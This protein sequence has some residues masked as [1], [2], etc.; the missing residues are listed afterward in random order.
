V[1]VGHVDEVARFASPNVILL[2]EV[3]KEEAQRSPIAAENR[4]RLEADYK[5]LKAATDQ[6]GKPFTII[7]VPAANII[8]E[9]MT[10]EDLTYQWLSFMTFDDGSVFP[11]PEPVEVIAATG[12]MNYV[13]TNGIV[14]VPKYY[15]FGMPL[16]ILK[17]DLQ[18]FQL[19]KSVFP[20]RMVVAIDPLAINLGGGGMHCI[21]QQEP[22]AG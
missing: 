7:R 11:A 10:P 3:T 9:T 18:V 2:A 21:T 5:V 12:Y 8:Y 20:G 1:G 13:V 22:I 4:I 14:L 19:F 6:N 16:S 17:K 15:K